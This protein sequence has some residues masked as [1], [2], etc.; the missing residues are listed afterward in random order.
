MSLTEP[1]DQADDCNVICPYCGD[2]YQAEAEDYDE[3]ERE[4]TCFA[5]K[6]V[7]LLHDE[8]SITHCTRPVPAPLT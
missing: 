1:E 6:R 2:S 8:C 4:E 7:Y 5:C 3:R